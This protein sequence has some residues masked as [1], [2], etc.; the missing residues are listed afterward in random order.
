MKAKI[1][2]KT[3][4]ATSQRGFGYSDSFGHEIGMMTCVWEVD[5]VEVYGAAISYHTGF[6]APGHYFVAETQAT[7]NG[8]AYGASQRNQ[9]FKTGEARDAYLARRWA[10]SRK[11]A[12]KEGSRLIY[13][14]SIFLLM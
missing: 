5:V 9:Y 3:T 1:I 13:C 12:K 8:K 10:D 11:A 2:N 4:A 7:R 14:L 6:S